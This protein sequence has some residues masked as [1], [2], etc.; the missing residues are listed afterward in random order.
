MCQFVINLQEFFSKEPFSFPLSQG[1][2]FFDLSPFFQY[3]T[4]QDLQVKLFD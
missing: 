2:I 4:V 1:L 3:L